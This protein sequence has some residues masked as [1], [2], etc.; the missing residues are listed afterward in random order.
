[1]WAIYDDVRQ[2][3]LVHRRGSSSI[4]VSGT[5]LDSSLGQI[6]VRD[7]Y[8]EL[9]KVFFETIGIEARKNEKCQNNHLPKWYRK[10]MTEMT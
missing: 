3:A 9:W 1:N 6:A 2:K 5:D 8:E 4:V 7:D 10:N